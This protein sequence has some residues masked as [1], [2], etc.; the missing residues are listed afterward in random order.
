MT[1]T[2][3]ETLDRLEHEAEQARARVS[4]QLAQVRHRLEPE[5]IKHQAQDARIG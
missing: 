3:R 2:S 5:E 4:S 1:A